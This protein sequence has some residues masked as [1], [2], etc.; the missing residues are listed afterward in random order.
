MV[1]VSR[2]CR[3]Q[4]SEGRDTEQLGRKCFRYDFSEAGELWEDGDLPL[5][6][7]WHESCES[8]HLF[9]LCL[10]LLLFLIP[11]PPLPPLPF[12]FP[13]VSSYALS[14]PR[15]SFQPHTHNHMPPR[16]AVS[17]LI[18]LHTVIHHHTAAHHITPQHLHAALNTLKEGRTM[19]YAQCKKYMTKDD[20]VLVLE[21][22]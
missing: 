4:G 5:K 21:V 1:E 20:N 6:V 9:L 18:T 12:R 2:T 17:Y 11:S 3:H 15:V 10:L 14:H 7:K 16:Q 19:W 13:C 22:K 8:F